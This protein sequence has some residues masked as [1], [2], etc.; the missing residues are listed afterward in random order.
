MTLCI[1]LN[2]MII[3]QILIVLSRDFIITEEKDSILMIPLLE[4][5]MYGL[6]ATKKYLLERRDIIMEVQYQSIYAVLGML[7]RYQA[8]V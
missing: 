3:A 2:A 6:S 4:P 7:V 8:M 5:E 1:L